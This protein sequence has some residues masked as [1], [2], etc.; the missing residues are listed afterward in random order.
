[1]AA[2]EKP[3]ARDLNQV[4]RYTMWSVFRVRTL[5]DLAPDAVAGEVNDLLEQAVEKDVTTRGLYDVAGT[6]MSA[7]EIDARASC[8][9]RT[10]TTAADR[11]RV[12]DP[13]DG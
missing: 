11:D 2:M 13:I 12:P 4:I 7:D 3:K 9:S 10:S 6:V 1:M 8:P 5:G